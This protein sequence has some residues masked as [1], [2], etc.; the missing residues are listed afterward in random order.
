M[1]LHEPVTG[2]PCWAELG[3]T[4]LE[5]AKR[6]Y[7]KLFGWRPETDPRQRAGGYTIARI[8]DAPVAALTPLYQ[9]GQPVAWNVSFAVRDADA[10]A[11]Q[12]TAAG[13]VALQG[14]ADVFDA[15]RFA[16]ADRK[17]VV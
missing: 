11:R 12:V 17:S 3:T 13:G 5:A 15:G 16:V 10:A 7:T 9:Q 2:G 14:P 1:K 6:F 4:D 8:D